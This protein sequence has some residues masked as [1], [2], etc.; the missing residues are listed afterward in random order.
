MDKGIQQ[1]KAK[2]RV[3]G[4][5]ISFPS[6]TTQ[7][8]LTL[9][10]AAL[11]IAITAPPSEASQSSTEPERTLGD[12][13]LRAYAISPSRRLVASVGSGG[14]FLWSLTTGELL[15]T[16]PHGK[17]LLYGVT[18]SDDSNRIISVGASRTT[19]REIDSPT[20]PTSFPGGNGHSVSFSQSREI[21]VLRKGD[22][23][24]A[25]NTKNGDQLA[26]LNHPQVRA[27][28]VD[29]GGTR[30]ITVGADSRAVLWDLNSQQPI[31]TLPHPEP[32]FEAGFSPDASRMIIGARTD[33]WIWDT[34]SG[35]LLNH[36]T[37]TRSG[38]LAADNAQLATKGADRNAHLWIL[39]PL[40]ELFALR[41]NTAPLESVLFSPGDQWIVGEGRENTF[42]WNPQTGILEN[43]ISA[44]RPRFSP[45]GSLFLA[46]Q[47]AGT[48]ELWES[49]PTGRI[50]SFEGHTS[51]RIAA[52]F[53]P[54]GEQIAVLNETSIRLYTQDSDSPLVFDTV[55]ETLNTIAFSPSGDRILSAGEDGG[56][57][58]WSTQTGE[59]LHSRSLAFPAAVAG[60][61]SPSDRVLVIRSDEASAVWNSDLS[62]QVYSIEH[63]DSDLAAFSVDPASE[64]LATADESGSLIITQLDSGAISRSFQIQ[65]PIMT[66]A[67]TPDGESIFVGTVAGPSYLFNIASGQLIRQIETG[68][69][70]D[71]RISPDGSTLLIA[72]ATSWDLQS[73]EQK[74]TFKIDDRQGANA[75]GIAISPDGRFIAGTGSVF[76]ASAKVW[77][78]TTGR[79]VASFDRH[80]GVATSIEFFPDSMSLMTTASDGR[81]MIWKI[82]NQASIHIEREAAS[83]KVTWDQG[84]LETSPSPVG[85]WLATREQVSPARIATSDKQQFFRV[86]P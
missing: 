35:Q 86:A 36:L 71:S 29:S 49:F 19:V 7:C 47:E 46:R 59:L 16:F 62:E 70:W 39:D 26:A 53:S 84:T 24:E 57:T 33:I 6:K 12:G 74:H 52:T 41:G 32:L 30:V 67:F 3:P 54:N 66:L 51:P 34:N 44:I 4:S 75:D 17:D 82:P 21:M 85:P 8:R 2:L 28:S 18:F 22:S 73:G 11:A 83:V 27:L 1:N 63:H 15:E 25:W 61:V 48:F 56:L 13:I 80:E 69:A 77:Q 78:A 31:H 45:D 20:T 14:T 76:D 10:I 5:G 55:P 81:V 50:R 72:G 60:F 65:E 79:L 43:E 68:P 64:Q 23:I 58:L 40:T 9:A 42:L 38:D 37:D